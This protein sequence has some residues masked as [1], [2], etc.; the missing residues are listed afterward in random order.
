MKTVFLS[1]ILF[2]VF[3]Y[4]SQK[5]IVEIYEKQDLVSYRNTSI[6]S[7]L[8]NPDII[9]DIDTC[10][11]T[12]VFDFN[13]KTMFY[14][15]GVLEYSFPFTVDTVSSKFMMIRVIQEGFNL[16]YGYLISLNASNENI[17]GYLFASNMTWI[18]KIN[19]FKIAYY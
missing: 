1:I 4:F 14:S 13:E 10:N 16:D 6:D 15:D 2:F 18:T 9:Y 3:N 17:T 5:L 12:Y 7:V 11:L 8:M 19:K